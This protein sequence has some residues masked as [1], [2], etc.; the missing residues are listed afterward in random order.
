MSGGRTYR[1]TANTRRASTYYRGQPWVSMVWYDASKRYLGYKTS[2]GGSLTYWHPLSVTRT[3]PTN[4]RFVTVYVG[5]NFSGNLSGHTQY[6]DNA[7]L[8]LAY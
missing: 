4:A 2:Y 5:V 7:T 1:F 6:W 3:L 8:Q